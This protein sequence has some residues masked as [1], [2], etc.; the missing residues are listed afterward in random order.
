MTL[1]AAK[2]N[3]LLLK[4]IHPALKIQYKILL[5][6]TIA[7]IVTG[8]STCLQTPPPIRYIDRQDGKVKTEQVVAGTALY[9]LYTNPVGKLGLWTFVKRKAVSEIYG[10]LMDTPWST[11]KIEPF[12]KK[13]HIPLNEYQKQH[14]NSFNDFFTRKLKPGVRTIDTNR[15]VVVSPGDGK[16]LAYANIDN[17]D[18]IVKGARFQVK[19]FLQNDSLAN[20]YRGGSLIIL[21]LCPTDYHRY[22]FP[23]GGKVSATRK[24]EG[25]YYSVSP[26]AIKKRIEIF[27]ENKRQY[28]IIS[29]RYFG[30]VL[31]AEVGATMVGSMVET[32]S[33]DSPVRKGIEKGY[34]KFGGSTVLLLFVHGAITIDSDLLEN[35]KNHLETQVK[36]GERIAIKTE[37]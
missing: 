10:R 25:D 8:L 35:T 19:S 9:W 27:C 29:S 17:Q 4:K 23:V 11:G 7:L 21:R 1:I 26:L 2:L 12:V 31:M 18:F 30:P 16:M 6:L 37:R 15:R 20:L 13:Y 34:F 5:L 22:H 3:K 28:D 32:Y 14:F 33:P 24:I 36:M